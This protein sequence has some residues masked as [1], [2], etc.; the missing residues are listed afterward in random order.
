MEEESSYKSNTY[1]YNN[2]LE[3]NVQS[4]NTGSEE[5]EGLADTIQNVI[6]KV[7]GLGETE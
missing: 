6:N 1:S 2:Q 3:G 4:Q 7:T 5:E